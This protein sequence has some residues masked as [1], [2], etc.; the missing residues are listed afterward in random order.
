MIRR[1][2]YLESAYAFP[3]RGDRGGDRVATP[4]HADSG[5][6]GN[7]APGRANRQRV[8]PRRVPGTGR[9]MP[10]VWDR[11]LSRRI[12]WTLSSRILGMGR[13]QALLGLWERLRLRPLSGSIRV[14]PPA[15]DRALSRRIPRPIL[16]IGRA[17]GR[18][19]FLPSIFR[20]RFARWRNWRHDRPSVSR[21][22]VSKNDSWP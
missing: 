5:V 9:R 16:L 7:V 1:R 3:W 19:R 8:W 6:P 21:H 22:I 17:E 13:T 15:R 14:L 12:L 10:P 4:G 2:L 18:R 11:A 20:A